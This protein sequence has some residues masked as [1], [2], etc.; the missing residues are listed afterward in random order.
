MGRTLVFGDIHGAYRALVQVM[1]RAA[2]TA[3][4]RLI[5]LGDYVDGWSQTPEVM[6]LLM[7]LE[8]RQ[9]SVFII[10]NHDDWCLEWFCGIP[11]SPDWLIHGGQAT[12]NSYADIPAD[13]RARHREFFERMLPYY[14]DGQGRLFVHAGFSSMHGPAG[15]HF[16]SNFFWDRT[17]W[18][19]AMAADGRVSEES[20]FYPKRLLLY[21]EIF[22]GHTPTTNFHEDAPMHKCNVWNIDTGAAFRGRL[23]ILDADTKEFWQSDVVQNLYPGEK[24]RN[25]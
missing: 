13:R 22:I 2:V 11:P 4:D 5:F 15:E 7:A 25:K 6:D 9:D 23:S 10:G 21:G 24:G 12:V 16:R 20:L 18:E 19:V 8:K 3:A 14:D 1:D 17:L